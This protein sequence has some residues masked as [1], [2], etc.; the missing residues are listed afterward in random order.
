MYKGF[1]SSQFPGSIAADKFYA[2][3]YTSASPRNIIAPD[4]PINYLHPFNTVTTPIRYVKDGHYCS[5]IQYFTTNRVIGAHIQIVFDLPVTVKGFSVLVPEY[6][7]HFTSVRI[8]LGNQSAYQASEEFWFYSGSAAPMELITYT[9]EG[10]LT[11]G[12]YFTFVAT[13]PDYLGMAELEVI[14]SA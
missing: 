2:A 13:T 4:T 3:C 14:P 9:K 7:S 6:P 12:K 10:S 11:S 8:Y 1:L 5:A